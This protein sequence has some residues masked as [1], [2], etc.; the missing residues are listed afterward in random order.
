ML[1]SLFSSS[2]RP[3]MWVRMRGE[4]LGLFLLRHAYFF[5]WVF[6]VPL[7]VW[8]L[9][10]IG[11]PNFT[12]AIKG[13]TAKVFVDFQNAPSERNHR[14]RFHTV[15]QLKGRGDGSVVPRTKQAACILAVWRCS[16]FYGNM[17]L[18]QATLT[19]QQPIRSECGPASPAPWTRNDVASPEGPDVRVPRFAVAACK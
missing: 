4:C 16:S 14:R 1:I 12:M 17:S 5:L 13:G 6:L 15:A 9:R 3:R 11:G 18:L 8:P 7:P 10:L 19:K 2:F